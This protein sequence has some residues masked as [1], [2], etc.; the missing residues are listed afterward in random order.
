M[1]LTRSNRIHIA[2]YCCKVDD[3]ELDLSVAL[4]QDTQRG[5]E[6]ITFETTD[7]ILYVKQGGARTNILLLSDNG[8]VQHNRDDD[9]RIE[10]LGEPDEDYEPD[11]VIVRDSYTGREFLVYS[12]FVDNDDDG[13]AYADVVELT[14]K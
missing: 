13:C 14:A 6:F 9:G 7:S 3:D 4:I 10:F 12:T 2:R 11:A 1:L 5:K 8:G